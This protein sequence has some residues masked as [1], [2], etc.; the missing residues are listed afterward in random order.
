MSRGNLGRATAMFVL[1]ALLAP[2]CKPKLPDIPPRKKMNVETWVVE[3]ADLEEAISLPGI[4]K[5]DRTI[6]LSA[7]V[8]AL[9][10]K[11]HVDVGSNVQA[12][13]TLLEFDDTDLK[14]YERQARSGV[15]A[16]EARLAEAKKGAREQ[17][18]REAEAGLEAAEAGLKLAKTIAERRQKL[19]EEKVIPIEALDQARLQLQQAQSQ[20]DRAKELV[21][22]VRE[23]AT[24][25][26]ILALEA[27]LEGARAGLALATNRLKKATVKSPLKGIVI[28]RQL[29]ENEF[30]GPGAPL[31]DII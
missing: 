17:Q 26:T 7:E 8:S 13:Q 2:A 18:I 16:L 15:A 28:K 27:Q 20:Y 5:Q 22:L 25:E 14:A 6:R 11:V 4:V 21:D 3:A 31:F 1:A 30:T 24:E 23:G 19:S 29:D 10:K 12:G 9:A